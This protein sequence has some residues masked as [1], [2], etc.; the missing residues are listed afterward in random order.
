MRVWRKGR[1]LP[2]RAAYE[3]IAVFIAGLMV[4]R[5]PEFLGKKIEKPEIVLVSLVLLIH[6]L[7]ILAPAVGRS[8]RPTGSRRWRTRSTRIFR[9]SLCLH[10]FGRQQR[11]AFA[12]STPT[13]PGMSGRLLSSSCRSL[14]SDHLHDGGRG[15]DRPQTDHS[16]D[17]GDASHG[18]R[19]I[20]HLLVCDNIDRRRADLLSGAR[21]GTDRRVFRHEERTSFLTNPWG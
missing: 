13:R 18:H 7:V 8:S 6:P 17:D 12:G 4:G 9:S 16:G 1:R 14:P 15:L 2:R 3:M 20:R 19:H 11:S 21:S 5:T 10:Q